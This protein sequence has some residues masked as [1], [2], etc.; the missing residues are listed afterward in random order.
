MFGYATT[1]RIIS[2][3]RATSTMEFSLCT[4]SNIPEAAKK[5]KETLNLRK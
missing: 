2:G 3:G 1:L 5:Q 4:P